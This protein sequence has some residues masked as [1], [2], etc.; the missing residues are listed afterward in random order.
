MGGYGLLAVYKSDYLSS[1]GH[2]VTPTYT[3][4]GEDWDLV[5]KLISN[6]LVVLRARVPGLYHYHHDRQG[7]WNRRL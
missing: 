2:V 6:K 7:M 3:W 4:G 5:Q 1:N